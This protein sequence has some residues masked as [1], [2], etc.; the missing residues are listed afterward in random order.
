MPTPFGQ[1]PGPAERAPLFDV[2]DALALAPLPPN[3]EPSAAPLLDVGDALVLAGRVFGDDQVA[4]LAAPLDASH[5]KTKNNY[6]YLPGWHVINEANRIFGF[7]G[8]YR[9]TTHV[10]CVVD[11]ER[12]I[13]SNSR[14]GWGVTYLARVRVTVIEKSGSTII[15]DG[16]GAGSGIDVDRGIAHESAVKEAETDAMKRALITFGNPFGLALYDK[17]Q[18]QVTSS[19]NGANSANG[20]PPPSDPFAPQPAPYHHG[21]ALASNSNMHPG[22]ESPPGQWQYPPAPTPFI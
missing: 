8:W 4:A 20:A 1:A 15:R 13:G 16:T 11:C 6:S 19:A 17:E 12:T 9:E 18:R 5:V 14:L 21:Q 10:Q 22:W 7:D 3:T 2:G